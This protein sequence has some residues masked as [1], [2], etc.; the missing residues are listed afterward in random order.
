M[1]HIVGSQVHL[2][3]EHEATVAG[4]CKGDRA[5]IGDLVRRT[6]R[7]FQQGAK[8]IEVEIVIGIPGEK[9]GIAAVSLVI[10]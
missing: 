2:Q 5:A 1:G 3:G 6:R 7:V 4:G 10:I 8:S 9:N